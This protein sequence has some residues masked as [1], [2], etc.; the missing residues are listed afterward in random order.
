VT[1][2]NSRTMLGDSSGAFVI[3]FVRR[4]QRTDWLV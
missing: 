4:R 1:I 2:P 3:V